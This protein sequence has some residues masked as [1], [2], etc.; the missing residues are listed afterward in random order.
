MAKWLVLGGALVIGA[1]LLP[2][3]IWLGDRLLPADV[4]SHTGGAPPWRWS[5]DRADLDYCIKVH[6]PAEFEVE[7]S[8]PEAF[9]TP[10]K[11]RSKSG[12]L[13]YANQHAH[14]NTVFARWN[15]SLFVAEYSPISSG[16]SIAA[17]DLRSGKKLWTTY[18]EGIGLT[19]HSKYRNLVNIETDGS[20]VIVYG[21]EV[22]GRYVELLDIHT[23]KMISNQKLESDTQSLLR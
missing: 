1:S 19:G 12:L 11:I 6:L 21:N 15:H 13:A 20:R 3:T 16:C 23:G 5:K 14:R 4:V 10:I 22:H 17:V 18:L 7:R 9:Y 2:A 8:D